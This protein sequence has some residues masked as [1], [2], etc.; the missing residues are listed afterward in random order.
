[1]TTHTAHSTHSTSSTLV[2]PQDPADPPGDTHHEEDL[3]ADY[4]R[5]AVVRH[6]YLRAWLPA[7]NPV[8]IYGHHRVDG[9]SFEVA[10]RGM[11]V[12]ELGLGAPAGSAPPVADPAGGAELNLQSICFAPITTL[13]ASFYREL[14]AALRAHAFEGFHV[15]NWLAVVGNLV[16]GSLSLAS[17]LNSQNL[18]VPDFSAFFH[19][20]GKTQKRR[21]RGGG[22]LERIA[23]ALGLI[24]PNTR[25]PESALRP[26][27]ACARTRNLL[28]QGLMPVEFDAPVLIASDSPATFLGSRKKGFLFVAVI[29]PTQALVSMPSLNF[30]LRFAVLDLRTQATMINMFAL[31]TATNAYDTDTDTLGFIEEYLGWGT[32]LH[33]VNRNHM[34]QS[35][36]DCLLL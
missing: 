3:L 12:A 32:E 24:D 27:R 33:P 23:R 7:N 22:L 25:M 1:M 36:V 17:R 15:E 26:F 11:S 20:A 14:A 19:R 13:D 2:R 31:A 34:V 29:S 9:K 35:K 10:T 30:L 16:E 21:L 6:A 8:R 18:T 5:A 28:G 4:Q